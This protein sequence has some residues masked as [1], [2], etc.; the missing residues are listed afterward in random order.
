MSL[1]AES[2]CSDI[3][4]ITFFELT[5]IKRQYSNEQIPHVTNLKESDWLK[6]S[7]VTNLKE[8]DWLKEVT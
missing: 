2:D 3:P 4:S 8:S 7:Q 6:E 1:S 5:S